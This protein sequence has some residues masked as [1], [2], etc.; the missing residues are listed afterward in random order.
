VQGVRNV[1]DRLVRTGR[2]E[3]IGRGQYRFVKH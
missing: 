3:R 1:L 2:A